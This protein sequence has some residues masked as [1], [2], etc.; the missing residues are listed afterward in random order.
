MMN[1][2]F[3]GGVA[4]EARF[5]SH[6]VLTDQPAPVGTDSAMSPFDLFL[7]SIAT[8]MGFYALR[9]CQERDIPTAGLD[10]ALNPIRDPETKR[11]AKIEVVLTTPKAFPEKYRAALVRAVEL[12]SVKRHLHDPPEFEIT[13]G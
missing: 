8:C 5:G 1:V 6:T 7:A 2:T 9:F 12:C 4:V 13:S 3:P 11:V 10:L